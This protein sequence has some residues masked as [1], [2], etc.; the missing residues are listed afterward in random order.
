MSGEGVVA[1]V[2]AKDLGQA[3]ERL[4]GLLA[5]E[6]RRGLARAM[7][8]D[9]L[10]TL[11]AVP[12][13]AGILVVTR[14]AELAALARASGAYLMSDLR[15]EGPTAAIALAAR[16]LAADGAAAM[17]AVPALAGILVVT[18]DAELAAL[19]RASGAYLMSDLRHEGPTAAIALAAGRLAAEGAA[20]MLAVPADVPLATPGEI[21]EI[22]A[23]GG[24]PP[25]VTL[26]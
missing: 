10:T 12:P 8:E 2:P 22:L 5:P 11:R 21:M 24:A 17:L 14:D 15:H 6:E 20:A 4:A 1:V 25:A 3:K 19:A 13:L 18:R 23:A 9:V 26:V 16:R 7:L